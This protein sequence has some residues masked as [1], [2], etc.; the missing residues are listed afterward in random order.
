MLTLTHL[1]QRLDCLGT[2]KLL[3]GLDVIGR[4]EIGTLLHGN[5][6]QDDRDMNLFGHLLDLLDGLDWIWV[7]IAIGD[8]LLH[9]LKVLVRLD[10]HLTELTNR[11]EYLVTGFVFIFDTATDV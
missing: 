10:W 11:V 3:F 1:A 7:G 5:E 9:L 6:I 4:L 8:F 2:I